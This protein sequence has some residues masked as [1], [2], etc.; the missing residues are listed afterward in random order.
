MLFLVSTESAVGRSRL[1]YYL[2][3][4]PVGPYARC[5]VTLTI[6]CL[7]A[8]GHLASTASDLAWP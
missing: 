5:P 6:R 2:S 4:L 7:L 3:A 1:T 8:Y